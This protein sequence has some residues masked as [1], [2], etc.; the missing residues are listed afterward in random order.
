MSF[1]FS[2]TSSERLKTATPYL[3]K[4]FHRAIEI[5]PIDFGIAQGGRT[6]EQ[7]R[8]YFRDGKSKINPDNY[9]P[10]VLPL[11]AKH[12]ITPEYSKSGAVDIYAYIPHKGASWDKAHLCVIAGVILSID[13]S[14]ENKLR[15]GGNWDMDGEII[16]DQTFQDL[17]HFE[18]L[19][20]AKH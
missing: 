13:K 7:Q 20:R 9:D 19:V 12:I 5:T 8:E 6:I 3:N 11:K 18:E 1:A 4:V 14:M 15:W 16:S 2:Q 10:L 17:P